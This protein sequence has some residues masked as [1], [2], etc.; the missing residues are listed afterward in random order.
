MNCPKCGSFEVDT[1]ELFN[2]VDG[3]IRSSVYSYHCSKCKYEWYGNCLVF[4][5][6]EFVELTRK[7]A[8]SPDDLPRISTEEATLLEKYRKNKD[9]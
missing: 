1:T 3:A 9:I 5:D 8:N 7:F 2:E 4:V 6:K